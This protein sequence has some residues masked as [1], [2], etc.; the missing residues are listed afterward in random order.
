MNDAL[1]STFEGSIDPADADDAQRLFEQRAGVYVAAAHDLMNEIANDLDPSRFGIGWWAPHPDDKRRIFI[2]DYLLQCATSVSNNTV[3]AAL[4]LSSAH[5]A[6]AAASEQMAHAVV[7]RR[8]GP[9]DYAG[10]VKLPKPVTL[11]DM[12][13]AKLADLH[14]GGFF[15]AVGS[16]LD[17]VA[18]VAIAVGAF[19]RSIV[20]AD[21]RQFVDYLNKTSFTTP[22]RGYLQQRIKDTITDVVR[23]AGPAGWLD[24]TLRFRN[25]LVHRGRRTQFYN[26]AREP[27]PFL[28]SPDGTPMP[29]ARLVMHLARDPQN[30]DLQA[31][32]GGN[33][34]PS[35]PTNVLE[36]DG[37][38]ALRST[39]DAVMFVVKEL[40]VLLLGVWRER[41][42][43]PELLTQ[44]CG[45]WPHL[46]IH[47]DIFGGFEPNTSPVAPAAMLASRLNVRRLKAAAVDTPNRP[48]WKTFT[49]S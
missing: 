7:L 43:T 20:R 3:E 21:F 27:G 22:A 28:Y 24:W 41:R 19:E 13:P 5:H 14:V 31:F 39:L 17:T 8:V 36:E 25:M 11:V 18:A 44:P 16:T 35:R 9:E 26:I 29:R 4:H 40:S 30:S 46:A 45:Q 42:A 47:P 37:I 38:R 23:K 32:F 6:H 10:D 48:R 15:R 1:T 2:S 12:L 33:A 34:V 49:G